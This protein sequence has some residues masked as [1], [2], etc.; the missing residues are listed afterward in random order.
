MKKM[1]KRGLHKF[2]HKWLAHSEIK[3]G[4]F[5]KYCVFFF[6]NWWKGIPALEKFDTEVFD[7]WKKFKEI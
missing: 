2:Q 7:S 3:S 4:V 5:C 6:K 1:K